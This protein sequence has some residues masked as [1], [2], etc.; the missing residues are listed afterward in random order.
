M[1]AVSGAYQ[2]FRGAAD[3][4]EAWLWPRSRKFRI[5]VGGQYH[6][7]VAHGGY[8]RLCTSVLL[9][10]DPLHLTVNALALGSLGRLLEPWIGPLRLLSW[11]AIGGF[12]GA[13]LSQAV[14]IV[15]TDGAS[16]GAFALLGA[17]VVL[18]WRWRDQLDA[19]DRRLMGPILQ[20]FLVGNLVLSFLLPFVNAAG[21]VGGLVAGLAL[22]STWNGPKRGGTAVHAVIVALFVATCVWG[23]WRVVARIL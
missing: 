22:G 17:A 5:A 14:G 6:P 20:A 18:G 3:P 10:G 11:F 8:W 16:G 7:L 2:W 21:H 4:L 13:V 23:W 19:I 15:Q 9:H 12:A 1:Y